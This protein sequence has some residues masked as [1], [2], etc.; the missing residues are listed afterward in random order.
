MS[1]I[2]T[3]QGWDVHRIV[4]GRPMILGGVAIACEFGLEGHS[5]A[6]VVVHAVSAPTSVTMATS[7]RF[8]TS[9]RVCRILSR[10]AFL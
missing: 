3:G 6:D 1:E 5:D 4:A 9:S 7:V 8:M 10:M 2:R